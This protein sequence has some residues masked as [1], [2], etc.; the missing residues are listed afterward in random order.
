MAWYNSS[1]DLSKKLTPSKQVT[2]V[3]TGGL[4]TQKTVGDA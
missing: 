1:K 3:A 4:Y 2:A